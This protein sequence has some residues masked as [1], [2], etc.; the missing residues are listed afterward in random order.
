[1]NAYVLVGGRSRR[2]GE[3]KVE[4][5]LE[6]V[7][8]AARPVFDEVIAVDRLAGG[9]W[10][11]GGPPPTANR[12]PPTIRTLYEDPHEHEGAIFG[13]V[14]ALR[15]ARG[16]CF[17]LAVDYPLITSDMLRFIRD[18]GGLPEWDGR[19]QPLCAVWDAAL[20]PRIEERIARGALDLRGAAETE[21]IPES[22]LRVRFPGEPL[23]NVNT[24]EEWER[25]QRFLASR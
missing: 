7:V 12:Q 16:K 23:L 14:R 5:F 25:A 10:T 19:P 21:I 4:L 8:S 9:P 6:R 20:L 24:P 1:M 17:L 22:E 3:S 11:G 18:R 2:M 13:V 15:D